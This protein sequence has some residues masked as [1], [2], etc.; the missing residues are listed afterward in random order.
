MVDI[1]IYV[2]LGLIASG[3]FLNKKGKQARHQPKITEKTQ[4]E[5][6]E[7]KK[8]GNNNIYDSGYFQKVREI[9]DEHVIPTFEKSFD[10]INTNVIPYFFN[11]L[12]ETQIKRVRNPRHDPNLFQKELTKVMQ[13]TPIVL[14]RLEP[15]PN[16]LTDVSQDNAIETGGWN[17]SPPKG[18]FAETELNRGWSQLITRPS[19]THDGTNRDGTTVPLTHN[20]MVPFFGGS[21]R[22]NMEIDNRMLEGK[23]ENFTGQFKLD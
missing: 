9:E 20:N 19:N 13:Q 7:N 2:G 11:S 15:T 22:Q 14:S 16:D 4:D 23:L 17:G 12:N 8:S 5:I 3:Y 10:P 21:A 6:L 1:P 18:L